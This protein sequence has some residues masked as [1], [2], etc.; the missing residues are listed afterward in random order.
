MPPRSRPDPH[1]A[2]DPVA[3]LLAAYR[4][5]A[6]P[7]ADPRSGRVGWFSADPRALI[8]IAAAPGAPGGI[9]LSRSL[10]A[11][12]Y[13][14]RAPRLRF[15][16]DRAFEQ[17]IRACAAPRPQDPDAAWISTELIAAYLALHHAGHA[18]SIEAWR[19][20]PDG[21]DAL[22]GGLYGVHLA[23]A[24]FGESM[25]C[26]PDLGG[27]DASKVALVRLA[28]HLRA[29]GVVILDTQFPNAH[30]EQFGLELAPADEYLARLR[31]ALNMPITWRAIA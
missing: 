24:F 17:V 11:A 1:L 3:T 27:T 10:R 25:F 2:R 30:M 23:G 12:A 18:H 28:D 21:A 4:A 14:S 9:R 8:P 26:R 22:V 19:T 7:M 6:F 15:T 5:G 20:Q 16:S 29:L 13:G 31:H